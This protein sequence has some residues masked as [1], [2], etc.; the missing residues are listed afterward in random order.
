MTFSIVLFLFLILT[1]ILYFLNIF[2]YRPYTKS[3]NRYIASEISKG[4]ASA[5]KVVL[6]DSYTPV[7]VEYIGSF[8]PVILF[9]FVLR[10]FVVEPFRI[11]SGSMLPTLQNGDLIL[12][13]K[14]TYGVRLPIIDTKVIDVNDP[15]VGD[16]IVFRYPLDPSIDYIKRIVAVGGDRIEYRGK[17]LFINGEKQE[18]TKLEEYYNPNQLRFYAHFEENLLGHKHRIIEDSASYP[19]SINPDKFSQDQF[20]VYNPAGFSCEVPENSYFVMGD[21]RDNSSD[22]RVWGFV[23]NS[24]VVGKAFYIWMNL[25]DLSRIGFFR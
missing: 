11:P 15:Q 3:Y 7:W 5:K 24:Q 16:V 20:C 4:N 17:R 19:N 21:N 14:Y 9:V 25:N 1:G 23:S 13:N 18:I 22:S 6:K 2:Y 12:V 10:S 8:F